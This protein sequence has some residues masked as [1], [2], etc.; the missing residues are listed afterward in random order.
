[1]FESG[2]SVGGRLVN[3]VGKGLVFGA[4]GFAAGIFG[5]AL[6]NGLLALR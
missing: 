1:M 3:F 4:I 6:S 2:F 5:T